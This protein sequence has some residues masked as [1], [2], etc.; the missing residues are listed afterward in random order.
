[1]SEPLNHVSVIIAWIH[2]KNELENLFDLL[3]L[4]KTARVI[5]VLP[6]RKQQTISIGIKLNPSFISYQDNNF[7]DIITVL[8]KIQTVKRTI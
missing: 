7:E 5:L 4:I 8:K 3:P 2:K 6:D 1:M